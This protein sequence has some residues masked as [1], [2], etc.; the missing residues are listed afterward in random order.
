[1]RQ[2]K[3]LLVAVTLFATASVRADTASTQFVPDPLSVQRYGAGYRYP[4]AGWIVLHIEGEPYERG[5]QHGRL[6]AP[7][8]AAFVRCSAQL[9]SPTAP[10]D[11]WRVARTLVN[12]L[13]LRR[14]ERE[15]LEEMKGIADGA[16]AAGARFDNRPVDLIDIVAVNVW[17]EFETLESALEALPTGLEGVKFPHTQPRAMPAPK[18]MHCSAFAATGPATKDGKVVFGHIT[19]F[20]LYPANF[21]NV[22]LDVK[23]S[24]GHRVMMQ[25]YPGG[26]QSGLDYYMNDAG[27]LVTETTIAQTRYDIAGMSLASRIRQAMQYADT[28]DAACEYLKK[29]NN[30]LYT[31]E[32]LLAD[33]KTNEVAMFELGTAKTKL[34]R[35]SK[36][37]WVGGTTGFYWGCN[38]TK[39]REVRLETIPGVNGRP[40]N[41]CFCPSD[42]DK[43]WVRLYEEH[44]GK[45]DAD[46]GKLAFST[47]PIAAY[48]SLDAK[49][50]TTDLAKDLKTWALFGAPLGRSWQPSIEERKRYPEIQPLVG[51]PWTILHTSPPAATPHDAPLA[52]DL[53]DPNRSSF[54]AAHISDEDQF[55]RRRDDD[56]AGVLTNP[57]WHGTLLPKTD[58]DTWLAAAFASYERIVAHANGLR[59]RNEGR[60][61]T[62]LATADR[63]RLAVELNGHRSQYLASARPGTAR[64]DGDVPLARTHADYAHSDWYQIASGKGVLV[65]HELRHL[66]GKSKFEEAM[67]SFGREHAGKE[68]TAAE[69]QSHCEKVAGK[70][71]TSFFDYWLQQP[72]L[73]QVRLEKVSFA[74]ANKGFKVEGEIVYE[75][76][77]PQTTIEVS[78]ETAHGDELKAIPV[79]ATRTPF[80]IETKDRPRRVI[81]DKYASTAKTNGGVYTVNT[82]YGEL[83]RTLIVYGT[84]DEAANNK[85]SAEDLQ[86]AIIQQWSNFT[87]PIKSDRE[88]TDEDLS[89]H[90]LLLIGRPDTNEVIKRYQ[91][92]LPITFGWRSFKVRNDTYAHSGSAVVAAADNP[93]NQ[94]YSM[95]VIAGLS[96]ESTLRNAARFLR[97]GSSGSE[98]VIFPYTGKPLSVVVPAPELVKEFDRSDAITGAKEPRTA[99]SE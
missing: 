97:R 30:G 26:I 50:T 80:A 65:L 2:M 75:S 34:Y 74:P 11:G 23:P 31:N 27:I 63:D 79:H 84:V 41:M 88:V 25:S 21:Y 19:M 59:Q 8:I 83:D 16:A 66:L 14:Y 58:A 73:P 87:V 33:V 54:A 46:F 86:K 91:K 39:D 61:N 29:G 44:K 64:T 43:V 5:Y 45:I 71:L 96:P 76:P 6:L 18:P 55:R 99:G 40:E 70:S 20:G 1:M 47:P 62:G 89:T 78:V 28:I 77:F 48:H 3:I 13:F 51:N 7:E 92:G 93:L 82:W 56:D 57:A 38:N 24:N 52:L 53:H 37:E 15:Y 69:F 95:V 81:V 72:G 90:H 22:W 67:D 94:R 68:V 60:G 36:N 35:S 12:A 32:W 42:R 17:P 10:A 4:Q 98:V 85:E 49:F 9:T